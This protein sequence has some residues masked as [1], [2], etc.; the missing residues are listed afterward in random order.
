[1]PN[2]GWLVLTNFWC[3][4]SYLYAQGLRDLT[5]LKKKVHVLKLK[6]R[7]MLKEK[8][9]LQEINEEVKRLVKEAYEIIGEPY[10]EE[11]EVD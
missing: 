1:M 7:M 6:N 9:V 3:W 8:A 2:G 11:H 10:A 4:F 5:E